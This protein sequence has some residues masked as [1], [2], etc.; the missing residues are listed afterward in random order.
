MADWMINEA[1]RWPAYV[2]YQS[3]N[4]TYLYRAQLQLRDRNGRVVDV[5]YTNV[6]IARITKNIITAFPSKS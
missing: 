3:Y 4:D 2:V 6:V 1:L 5:F